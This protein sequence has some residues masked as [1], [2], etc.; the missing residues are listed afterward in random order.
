[1]FSLVHDIHEIFR[2]GWWQ[3]QKW[4]LVQIFL[5]PS[6]YKHCATKNQHL[7]IMTPSLTSFMIMGKVILPKHQWSHLFYM[8]I[9]WDHVSEEFPQKP[10]I[11]LVVIEGAYLWKV[12]NLVS[13]RLILKVGEH[14]RYWIQTYRKNGSLNSY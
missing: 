13:L 2:I 11:Q 4:N 6:L 9:K 14:F 12:A 7:K 5:M 1:M 10:G 3:R 8:R